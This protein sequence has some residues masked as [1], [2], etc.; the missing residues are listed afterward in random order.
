MLVSFKNI[1]GSQHAFLWLASP[2]QSLHLT[3]TKAARLLVGQL[4]GVYLEWVF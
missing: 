3:V 1:L 2:G 4:G